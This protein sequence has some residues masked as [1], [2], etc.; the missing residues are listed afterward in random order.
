MYNNKKVTAF[1]PIKLN[2]E[3]VPG[4]NLKPMDDGKLLISFIL[5]T[6]ME[7]KEKDVVNEIIVYCSKKEICSYLPSEVK[8]LKR[9]E[10]LDTQ[11]TKSNDI[12]RS[13]LCDYSSDLYVMCHA[14]SPFMKGI[15][16]EDCIRAVESGK[17]DSAFCAREIRN[18]M[19]ENGKPLN[20]SRD[21]YPRT[22]DLTPVY[23]ELPTP[24]VFTEEIFHKTGGRTGTNPYICP[25]ST[26]EAIDIDNP[27]DFILAN[28]IYMSGIDKISI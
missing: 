4:K 11:Y 10:D 13:F 25:C 26:I 20:F 2:N 1:I 24:Y 5:D 21:N 15:H 8:W 22:Q 28:A 7:L 12:I 23:E 6:L 16:I 27:N 17:Y 19:W 18:F 14:T 3:R 9:S